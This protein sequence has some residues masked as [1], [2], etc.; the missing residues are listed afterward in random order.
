MAEFLTSEGYLEVLQAYE[1][2]IFIGLGNEWNGGDSRHGANPEYWVA[3]Y[4]EA[5]AHI[6][7]HG[8]RSPLV[9]TANEWGQGCTTVLL[10]SAGLADDNLVFDVHTYNYFFSNT[11]NR[12]AANASAAAKVNCLNTAQSTG[13]PIV[14]G[15]FGSEHGG[16]PVDLAFLET[17]VANGQGYFAWNWFGDTEYPA[18]DMNSTWEGPLTAWGRTAVG[19][20]NKGSRQAT[21]FR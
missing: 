21:I 9:I 5:I 14:I 3:A 16:H 12:R 11:E 17:A 15:E 6:R 8:I 7:N 10:D 20:V 1:S 4:N 2:Y 18:L 13:I 19:W